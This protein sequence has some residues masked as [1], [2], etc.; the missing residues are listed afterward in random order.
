MNFLV[1][2]NMTVCNCSFYCKKRPNLSNRREQNDGNVKIKQKKKKLSLD[3][4][5]LLL[6]VILVQIGKEKL[7]SLNE[8]TIRTLSWI[9]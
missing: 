1:S 7:K 2:K 3:E 8:F 4:M 5:K 9:S 6:D